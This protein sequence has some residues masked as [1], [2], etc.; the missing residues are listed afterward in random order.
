M[1]GCRTGAAP[2]VWGT[3]TPSLGAALHWQKLLLLQV[4]L[5]QLCTCSSSQLQNPCLEGDFPSAATVHGIRSCFVELPQHWDTATGTG[6]CQ[7]HQTFGHWGIAEFGKGGKQEEL[8]TAGGQERGNLLWEGQYLHWP[9]CPGHKPTLPG[10]PGALLS[11]AGAEWGAQ[12]KGTE[13]LQPQNNP[14]WSLGGVLESPPGARIS[15]LF[16]FPH[17]LVADSP[18]LSHGCWVSQLE[19]QFCQEGWEHDWTLSAPGRELFTLFP[20]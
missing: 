6:L 17:P 5:I 12:S 18:N 11:E 1:S 9:W 20:Q 15:G 16:V 7:H 19:I 4:L 3:V 13:Q 8:S 2:W 10:C 14:T